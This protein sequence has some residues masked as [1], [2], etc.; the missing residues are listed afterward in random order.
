MNEQQLRIE[1]EN[2]HQRI[3]ELEAEHTCNLE[4]LENL[5]QA[6]ELEQEAAK[7][8]IAELEAE[9]EEL[10]LSFEL[11]EEASDTLT[12]IRIEEIE[13]LRAAARVVISRI[14]SGLALGEALDIQPLREALEVE[15]KEV[16]NE[17]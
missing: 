6:A 2:L 16:A 7:E 8:R 12:T 3:A 14:D 17:A 9:I 11:E 5:R 1:I 10:K 15:G 13:K 4:T